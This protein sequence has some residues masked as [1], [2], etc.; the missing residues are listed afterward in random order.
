MTTPT[1]HL[2]M[3]T[4]SGLVPSNRPLLEDWAKV[5]K[6]K[7]QTEVCGLRTSC[8]RLHKELSTIGRIVMWQHL[9]WTVWNRDLWASEIECLV[10]L[11][12]KH[13]HHLTAVTG[14]P[15]K[16][17]RLDTII[18]TWVRCCL[19]MDAHFIQHMGDVSIFEPI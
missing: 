7:W 3:V 5:F 18:K 12:I 10:D 11:W 13:A 14:P 17:E 9:Y 8:I 4:W 16:I 6:E 2:C 19:S 15:V 1:L